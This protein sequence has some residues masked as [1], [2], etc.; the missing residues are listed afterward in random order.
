MAARRRG[1]LLCRRRP[2]SPEQPPIWAV[3]VA[4]PSTARRSATLQY[5]TDRGR[6]LGRGRTPANPAALDPGA[7]LS[8]TTGAGARPDLQPAPP[9]ADRGRA[10][11]VR[12]AFT[13]AVADTREEALTLADQYHDSSGVTRAFELAWAHS[14][15]ELRHLHLSAEEA[16]LYQRLAVARHLRRPGPARR[17]GRARRQPRRA[18]RG[19]GGTA[20]PAT[21]PI[22][23][24]RIA[25]ADEL[26]AG[27][28]SCWP[29]TPTGGS[30]GWRSIW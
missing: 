10:A 1:A 19:C 22:V 5:E 4:A 3:H 30:R 21:G 12:V 25:E 15:V 18:S 16:H 20:S 24:V 17:A 29:P 8:G 11:S 9:G 14:Q 28:R 27:P 26:A 23:L 7:A 6:F 13:T 2:R